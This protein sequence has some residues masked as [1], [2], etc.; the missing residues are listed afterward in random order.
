MLALFQQ[1]F[2]VRHGLYTIQPD[3]RVQ[4]IT[5][6]LTP[7][8]VSLSEALVNT[9]DQ[10]TALNQGSLGALADFYL[11]RE[12]LFAADKARVQAWLDSFWQRYRDPSDV[13]LAFQTLDLRPDDNWQAVQQ[14]YRRLAL[15]CHPDKGGDPERFSAVREA[16]ET[17]KKYH[18]T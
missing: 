1:H 18:Q 12:Q 5:L 6:E 7:I 4:S 2:V 9:N 10:Q 8:G 16:Y 14:R 17:L 15:Q 11:D 3:L 13:E